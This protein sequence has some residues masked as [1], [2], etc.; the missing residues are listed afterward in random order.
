VVQVMSSLSRLPPA[1]ARVYND[2]LLPSLSLLPNDPEESVRVAYAQALAQLAAAAHEHLLGM[3]YGLSSDKQQQQQQQRVS[4]QQ[5]QQRSGSSSDKQPGAGDTAAAAAQPA[6]EPGTQPPGSISG[7]GAAGELLG[8]SAASSGS[9]QAAAAA[10]AAAAAAAVGGTSVPSQQPLVRYDAEMEAVRSAIEKVV[11]EL[12]AGLRSSPD[13]KRGL[14]SHAGQLG[15]FFG[16]RA[17]TDQLL[18]PLYT[19]LNDHVEWRL[20][21][22]FYA[23]IAALG[24]H[25]GHLDIFMLPYLEQVRVHVLKDQNVVKAPR[26]DLHATVLVCAYIELC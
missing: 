17:T 2:Y 6:G 22:S 15:V 24:P 9:G 14:L 12:V 20:R 16:R 8:G 5:Q 21:S 4:W 10:G 1:D 11:L 26:M 23:A 13:I 7:S 25:T 18:P 19:C 3:Q